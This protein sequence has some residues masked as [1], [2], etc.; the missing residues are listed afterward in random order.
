MR[1]AK[2]AAMTAHAASE[3]EQ[4]EIRSESD[5]EDG[6]L[7]Q[8]LEII[9]LPKVRLASI[10]YAAPRHL[11]CLEQPAFVART[12]KVRGPLNVLIESTDVQ[13]QP[14]H[15]WSA[16]RQRAQSNHRH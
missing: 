4:D 12:L 10:L 14:G 11:A 9:K 7:Y 5:G 3:D 15:L 16:I 2:A 1:A 13:T 6:D 8:E